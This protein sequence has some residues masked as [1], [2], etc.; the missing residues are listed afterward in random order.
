MQ[1]KKIINLYPNNNHKSLS[2]SLQVQDKFETRGF[3]VSYENNPN[4]DLN[5]CIGGDGAFLR[6]VHKSDFSNIPFVGINTGH[7]GFYQEILI[8]N[9]EN[10]IDEYLKSNYEIETLDLLEARV[11]FSDDSEALIFNALNE[12]VVKSSDSS[13]IHLDVLIDNNHLETFAGD[14]L[15][16]ST[17]SGSTAYNFSAGGSILYRSLK[18]YQLTPLAPINSKAYRS[19]LNSIVIPSMSTLRVKVRNE[20]SDSN[21]T[22]IIDGMS[23]E[24]DNLNYIDFKTSTKSISKLTFYKD[25]YWL[26]IKDKFL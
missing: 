22:L 4:A 23:N 3:Q 19:L 13:I 7:L 16:I 11:H 24:Y 6:A 26:N 2:I 8:P 1:H 15:L 14:A 5:I 10:F 17:P 25:W 18:G 20:D 9:I 21:S 12:F